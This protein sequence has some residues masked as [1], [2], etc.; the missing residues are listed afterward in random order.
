MYVFSFN[1]LEKNFPSP[2]ALIACFVVLTAQYEFVTVPLLVPIKPPKLDVPDTGPI[3]YEFVI[4]PLFSPIKPPI[5]DV[6][7]TAPIVYE[8]VIVPLF[9]PTN[10][11][12]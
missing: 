8:F 2:P 7:D 12:T 4:V 9:R 11:P 1:I 6:P 5:Y 10:P 3:A